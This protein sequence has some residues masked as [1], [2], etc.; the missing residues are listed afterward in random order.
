MHRSLLIRF[1]DNSV[2]DLDVVKTAKPDQFV[3]AFG[4]VKGG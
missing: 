1:S 4:A 3:D 2:V